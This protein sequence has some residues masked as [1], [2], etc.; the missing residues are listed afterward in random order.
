MDRRQLIQSAASLTATAVIASGT[1]SAANPPQP[2]LA[3]IDT[4]VSLF[5]WPCRRLPLD[6]PADLVAKLQSL[7]IEQAWACSFEALLHR[8]ITAVNQRLI[9][10][11][12]RFETLVPI[13]AINPMLAD[14]E[15]DWQRCLACPHMPGIRLYPNY[16]GYDLTA[17]EFAEVLRRA[18]EAGR[19][20][21]VAICMEDVR[22]QHPLLQVP[23]V[24]VRPLAAVVDSIAG[25]RVQLL[26]HRL[27]GSQLS[28][29]AKTAGIYF[30]T[31]RVD[32]S[33]GIAQLLDSLPAGRVL[34]G[35]HAPFLIPEAAL[36]RVGEA[37]LTEAQPGGM[38][39][40]DA[41][42]FLRGARP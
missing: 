32:G 33:D 1:P 19:F 3:I 21:Q 11:C 7:G 38:L 18:S 30:D 22:T 41:A 9:A 28:Q 23:D 36:I 39:S 40:T 29:L 35:S 31:A 24:D 16:H 5:Q 37:G 17:P 42:T 6:E 14:W 10:A 26:N 13:G 27:R 25:C 20:V 2:G 34:Y 8:D 15:T 12:Q 4:N